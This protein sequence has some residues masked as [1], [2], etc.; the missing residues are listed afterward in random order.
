MEYKMS[1]EE[2]FRKINELYRNAR[3]PKFYNPNIKRGR[4][5]SI[6]SE[7]ED[8]TALFI[9]LNNPNRCDYFTDQPMKFSGSTPKYPDIVIQNSNGLI[10]NIIDV[11]ADIGWDRSG[12]YSLCEEWEKRINSVKGTTTSFKQG[13]D[14]SIIDGQFSKNL[15][16]HVVVITKENSG[17]EIDNDYERVKR[18]LK[19][20]CLYILSDGLHPNEYHLSISEI[21][22][23]IHIHHD[24]FDRLLSHIV[25]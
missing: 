12:L 9:S 24:D 21:M 8:L 23:K 10:K 16:C 1:P 13:I 25:K 7:L 3:K 22:E 18:K 17:E 4:S 11:K 14:K 5:S 2:Y 20:V 15:K 6:S 19:N